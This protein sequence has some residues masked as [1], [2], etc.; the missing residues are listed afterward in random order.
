[1]SSLNINLTHFKKKK[2]KNSREV[3]GKHPSLQR[4][5]GRRASG[6]KD[7]TSS[8]AQW[9]LSKLSNHSKECVALLLCL[10][11]F[12]ADCYTNVKQKGELCPFYLSPSLD[13]HLP[14][15]RQVVKPRGTLFQAWLCYIPLRFWQLYLQ[16]NHSS[17]GQRGAEWAALFLVLPSSVAL[18][19]LPVFAAE[20][21]SP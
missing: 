2:G 10:E 11:W 13:A 1:M 12:Q 9:W 16:S 3:H 8:Q 21:L 18:F 20:D 17:I 4:S 6:Y 15:S 19:G 14:D 7:L 5:G